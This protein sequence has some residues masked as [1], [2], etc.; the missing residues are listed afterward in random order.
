LDGDDSAFPPHF[1][2]VVCQHACQQS[3]DLLRERKSV[4]DH[5]ESVPVIRT[6]LR[7]Q[8]FI[9][10]ESL[11]LSRYMVVADFRTGPPKRQRLAVIFA[12]NFSR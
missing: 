2:I 11:D 1:C 10:D 5:L 12:V 7:F 3:V 6:D 9:V 8:D 4:S